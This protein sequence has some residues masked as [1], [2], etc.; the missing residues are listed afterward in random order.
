MHAPMLRKVC[1]CACQC[2][3]VCMYVYM[4]GLIN[5]PGPLGNFSH[6]VG[7]IIFFVASPNVHAGCACSDSPF[8][9]I[10]LPLMATAPALGSPPSTHLQAKSA[11][12]CHGREHFLARFSG[13]R[14]KQRYLWGSSGYLFCAWRTCASQVSS[15]SRL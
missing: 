1:M 7:N 6:L 14:L 8:R 10:Y 12:S 4:S 9:R 11:P 3:H 13:N 5:I 2:A 15:L